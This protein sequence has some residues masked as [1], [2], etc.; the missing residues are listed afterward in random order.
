MPFNHLQ[1]QHGFIRQEALLKLSVDG[2]E[3]HYRVDW[4]AF[5]AGFNSFDSKTRMFLLCSPHNPTGQVYSKEELLRMAEI[6]LRQ[7]VV[8]VSDEI[9]SE[10]L[11][12]NSIH[13]PI[14]SLTTEIADRSVTLIAPSKTFN[15]PGLFCGFAIIPNSGLRAKYIGAMDRMTLH[16]NSLGLIAAHAAFSGACDAWLMDL[17]RYL[18]SNRDFIVGYIKENIPKINTTVP[19]ATYLAWFDFSRLEISDPYKYLLKHAKIALN[20]GTTFGTG[21]KGFVRFNFGT[22]RSL[23]AEGLERIKR[24]INEYEPV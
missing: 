7:D 15:I 21:G 5:N 23:V 8:I 9:H 16:V 17:R 13:A 22:S 18:T 4:D 3:L 24:A 10:I 12:G 2:N 19:D 1:H 14:A 11:L 20:D 6:C